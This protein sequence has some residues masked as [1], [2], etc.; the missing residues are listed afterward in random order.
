MSERQPGQ[1]Q[2][3]QPWDPNEQVGDV[4]AADVGSDGNIERID[5]L[6]ASP[7]IWVGSWADYNNGILHGLWIDAARD[8][9]ELQTDI[10]AMLTASPIAAQTG[11]PNEEWGVFDHDGFGQAPIGEQ[12]SLEYVSQVA[13]GIVEHGPAFGAFAAH[14]N[15][16]EVPD[17]FADRYLGH[18]ETIEDYAAQ[19]VD[20]LG[21]DELL[22]EAVPD[23]LRP[24]VQIDVEGL[25]RDMQLG[26][27]VWTADAE[28]GGVW[29]FD[30]R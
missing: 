12:P 30:G 21:Y 14:E 20:D 5:K 26:G 6:R 17:D 23:S 3:D 10:Q 29:I 9:P 24:Y 7:Q 15:G 28:D 22:D 27:D 2:P 18:Y 8:V 13:Q 25:A 11:M 1:P 16:S 19:L 4:Y